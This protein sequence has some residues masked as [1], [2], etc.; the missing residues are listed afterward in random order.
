MTGTINCIYKT[1][2]GWCSKWDKECDK[3]IN[4][5]TESADDLST[6]IVKKCESESD[7]E[8]ECTLIS[9]HIMHYT[10]K[11]CGAYKTIPFDDPFDGETI[12]SDKLFDNWIM[13][14]NIPNNDIPNC[15]K[16]C[17]NHPSNGGSG[18]CNCTL[19]YF[20]QS[21]TCT[22]TSNTTKLD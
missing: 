17:S 16:L 8:W 22:A 7:H 20:E 18:F 15:C 19:P 12:K 21:L 5:P 10:C 1:P 6:A 13:M 11:K 4:K 2:C 3:K 14:N 9:T